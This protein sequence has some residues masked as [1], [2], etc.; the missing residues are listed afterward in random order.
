[1][2]ENKKEKMEDKKSFWKKAAVIGAA[3]AT[4]FGA[5]IQEAEAADQHYQNNEQKISM[6][7]QKQ[8]G[9][10]KVIISE[11]VMP[12][13][14]YNNLTQQIASLNS[15]IAQLARNKMICERNK[16]IEGANAIWNQ[17]KQLNSQ[18]QSLIAELTQVKIKLEQQQAKS[19]QENSQSDRAKFVESI[20]VPEQMSDAEF[21][22]IA[23]EAKETGQ[24]ITNPAWIAKYQQM[25]EK[26]MKNKR[27]NIQNKQ[28]PSQER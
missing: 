4:M 3:T 26:N 8:Q 13:Q 28:A 7:Q 2:A 1:M 25:R 17:M 5:N 6:E 12:N 23:K 9:T 27:A 15:K 14:Q 18:K 22:K 11:K 21:W 19:S 24:K 16:N 20:K 10:Q